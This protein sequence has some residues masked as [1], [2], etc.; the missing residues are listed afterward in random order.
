ML[1]SLN[2]SAP[3]VVGAKQTARAIANGTAKVV[4]LAKDADAVVTEP[5]LEQCKAAGVAFELV[6]TMQELG[7]ACGIHVGAAVAAIIIP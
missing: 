1:E 4:F 6:E 3:R 5:L 2:G 7:K